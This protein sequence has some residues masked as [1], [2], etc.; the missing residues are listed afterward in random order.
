VRRNVIERRQRSGVTSR[1][2]IDA[3]ASCNTTKVDPAGAQHRRNSHRPG[4]S[5]DDERERHDDTEPES[6][7]AQHRQPFGCACPCGGQPPMLPHLQDVAA[8][9]PGLPHPRQEEQSGHQQQRQKCRRGKT[10]VGQVD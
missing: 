7:V 5:D 8:A 2:R 1:T 4:D 9:P 6:K 3:D 10:K